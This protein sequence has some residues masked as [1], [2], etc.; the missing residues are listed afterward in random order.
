MNEPSG[1]PEPDFVQKYLD[2]LNR[3]RESDRRRTAVLA[4]VDRLQRYLR[5]K[6]SRLASE[7]GSLLHP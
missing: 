2:L 7:R 1:Q 4:Q 6:Y 3:G 5:E